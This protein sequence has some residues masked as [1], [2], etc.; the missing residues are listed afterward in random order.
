MLW[1]HSL[2]ASSFVLA[3]TDRLHNKITEMS[4][5]IRQLEDALAVSHSITSS[6]SHCLLQRDLL[7]IKSII[8]LHSAIEQANENEETAEW[9]DSRVLDTFG[10]LALR[11]DGASTFYGRSAGHEVRILIWMSI[12]NFN[13]ISRASF[14]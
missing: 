5:R 7:Q 13:C 9:D 10:T 2:Y 12:S 14:W 8:D 1:P 6:D 4:A 11:D 3:D